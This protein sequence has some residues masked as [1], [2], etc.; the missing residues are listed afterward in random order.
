MI[1]ELPVKNEKKLML[2]MLPGDPFEGLISKPADSLQLVPEQQSSINC[3]FQGLRIGIEI[4]LLTHEP[5]QISSGELHVTI[6]IKL[7]THETCT[8]V[9]FFT[10]GSLLMG[11]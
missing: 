10:L 9:I 7:L 2:S 5:R 11:I 8:N 3:N 1:I 4:K 6:E